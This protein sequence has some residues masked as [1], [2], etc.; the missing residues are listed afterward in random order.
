MTRTIRIAVAVDEQGGWTASGWGYPGQPI[1]DE[2]LA[3]VVTS[4]MAR[5]A[6]LMFIEADVEGPVPPTTIEG[7]VCDGSE[8][9]P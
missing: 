9:K 2:I 8:R 4:R 7:K 6:K 5:T 3:H 1:R